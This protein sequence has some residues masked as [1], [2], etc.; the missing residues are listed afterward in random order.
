MNAIVLMHG[1]E[2]GHPKTCAGG[3]LKTVLAKYKK[4]YASNQ[5]TWDKI[6]FF[7]AEQDDNPKATI[8]YRL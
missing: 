4:S 6:M 3:A 8:R 2:T 7:A 1:Q 5:V